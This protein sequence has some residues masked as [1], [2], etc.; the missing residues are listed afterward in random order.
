MA[1]NIF[2]RAA[3]AGEAIEVFGDGL[4][5]RDFTYVGDVVAATRAAGAVPGVD[6]A[7][8]NIGGGSQVSLNEA[9]ALIEDIAGTELEVVHRARE[10]GDVRDTGADTAKARSELG[11]TASTGLEQGLA[12]EFEWLASRS[13][14][15][16]A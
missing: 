9:I 13:A 16:P 3:L 8:Y 4:Q 12:A 11:F 10:P 6:G 15:V 1:F 2:C 5:T 14:R 7:V